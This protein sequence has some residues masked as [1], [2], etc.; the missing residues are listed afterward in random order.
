M[1]YPI[2]FPAEWERPCNH[3]FL[4]QNIWLFTLSRLSK[5]SDKLHISLGQVLS[6]SY[7]KI[8]IFQDFFDFNIMDKRW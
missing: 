4:Q 2:A 3:I 1:I 6:L 5:E 7:E 8:F